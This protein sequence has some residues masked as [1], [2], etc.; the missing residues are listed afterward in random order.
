MVKQLRFHRL[1]YLILE[2]D[3]I[4]HHLKLAYLLIINNNIIS[5]NFSSFMKLAMVQV[6]PMLTMVLLVLLNHAG[7]RFLPQQS[8]WHM[9]LASI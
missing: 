8:V 2:Y 7:W 1:V 3:G 4:I 9:S 5:K 6:S